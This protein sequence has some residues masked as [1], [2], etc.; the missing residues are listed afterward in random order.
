MAGKGAVLPATEH[1]RVFGVSLRLCLSAMALFYPTSPGSGHSSARK[2]FDLF[3]WD[4]EIPHS[5]C[6]RVLAFG[7]VV[8]RPAA[9]ER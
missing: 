7:L 8:I 4:Q 1:R 2:S 3:L 9:R 5:H 6:E